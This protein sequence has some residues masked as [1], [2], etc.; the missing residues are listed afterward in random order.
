[1]RTP[2][3]IIDAHH[4]LWDLRANHYPWLMA[5]GQRRFFG[6]P[7]AIQEDYLPAHLRADIGSLP[8]HKSVHVQVGVAVGA[9]VDETRWLQ[10]QSQSSGLP[11]AIVAYVDLGAAD[12][13]DVLLR[14]ARSP[15][16]RG[17][18]QIIGRHPTEDGPAAPSRL[19]RDPLWRE[20][21]T[22]LVSRSL[23][24]DLQVI[25]SQLKEAHEVFSRYPDLHVAICHAGSPGAEPARY[26]EWQDGMVRWAELPRAC[27]K[28][29]GFGMFDAGW[30]VVSVKRCFETIVELFGTSRVM[31]GSN[32]PVERLARSYA[33][34]WR[35][36]FDLGR[37]FGERALDQMCHD[38][39][40]GFYRI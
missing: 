18:R 24:F 21:L 34:V 26:A 36:Y 1:M 32:Y 15:A 20:N 12:A 37:M 4:H 9:A 14:H 39:A 31:F 40:Q 3:R 33:D 19:L 38:N 7:T 22:L 13:D 30:S 29:S 17:V 16:F 11:T 35:D 5:R 27:C 10:A 25:P 2:G 28:F 6:D 23:S 8:V